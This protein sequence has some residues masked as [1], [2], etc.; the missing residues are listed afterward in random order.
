MIVQFVHCTGN[1]SSTAGC[2]YSDV[3]RCNHS[4]DVSVSCN[5]APVQDGNLTNVI[6]VDV[7]NVLEKI[8]KVKNVNLGKN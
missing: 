6:A 4:E 3:H 2:K 7:K 5:A 8:Q 1:E